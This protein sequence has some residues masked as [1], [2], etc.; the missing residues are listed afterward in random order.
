[1]YLERFS[2]LC[3]ALRFVPRF[4]A[5][6]KVVVNSQ[7]CV[8]RDMGRGSIIKRAKNGLSILSVMTTWA[9]ENS[10]ETADSMKARGYGMPGRTAYSIYKFDKRDKKALACIL[11]LGIYTLA[12]KILGM[13]DFSYFPSL[14]AENISALSLS[15]FAAYLLLCLFP[16]IIE[17]WEVRR[18]KALRSK[19]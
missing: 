2:L 4:A 3:S 19:I 7:K 15:V 14:K 13:V 12:G 1:M 18:W 16:V 17:L 6:L 8:G 5:Q 11:I 9:L 10:V